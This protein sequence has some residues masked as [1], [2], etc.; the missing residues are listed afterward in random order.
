MDKMQCFTTH[1][2]AALAC[3]VDLPPEGRARAL[4]YACRK[5]DALESLKVASDAPSG[6]LAAQLLQNLQQLDAELS[7]GGGRNET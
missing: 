3:Y 4:F 1:V 7:E 5:L 6:G 2:R